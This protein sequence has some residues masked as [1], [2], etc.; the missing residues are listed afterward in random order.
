[1]FAAT[2]F[3]LYKSL[4]ILQGSDLPMFA[5]GFVVSFLAAWSAIKFFLRFLGSHTLK[6]FGWYRIIVALAI[7]WL[8]G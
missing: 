4:T 5:I 6:P 3:D 2:A 8:L 1:M 7:L